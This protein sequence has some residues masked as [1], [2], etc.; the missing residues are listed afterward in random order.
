MI[1]G[2]HTHDESLQKCVED[3]IGRI[4]KEGQRYPALKAHTEEKLKLANEEI[5]QVQ[6]SWAFQENLRKKQTH[7][8][9]L[10]KNI[11]QKTNENN[12]LIRICDKFISKMEK[13]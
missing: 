1:E 9:S 11:G 6:F 12:E 10:E 3:Y 4:E 5:A 13:I 8:H 7:I 2:Y